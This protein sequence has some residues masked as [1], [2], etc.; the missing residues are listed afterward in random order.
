MLQSFWRYYLK[1]EEELLKRGNC[2]FNYS[3]DALGKI[4]SQN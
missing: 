3:G 4:K 1:R 2:L